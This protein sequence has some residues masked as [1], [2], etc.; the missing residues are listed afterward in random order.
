MNSGPVRG[1]PWGPAQFRRYTL[2]IAIGIHAYLYLGMIVLAY[3]VND[4]RWILGW[5]PLAI[6]LVSAALFSRLSYRWVMRLD[7]QY[8]RGSGWALVSH[9]VK[10]PE[11]VDRAARRPKAPPPAGAP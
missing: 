4:Q 8:G 7:A 6:A 5:K 3:V 9:A 10:L 2:A 11:L 1:F